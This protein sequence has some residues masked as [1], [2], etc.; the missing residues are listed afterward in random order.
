V[1]VSSLGSVPLRQYSTLSLHAP[2]VYVGLIVAAVRAM[3]REAP[4]SPSRADSRPP[5]TPPP[6]A[7]PAPPPADDDGGPRGW[8]LDGFPATAAQATLLEAALTGYVDPPAPV[9]SDAD[10]AAAALAAPPPAPPRLHA[11]PHGLDAV[12]RLDLEPGRTLRRAL[13][14]LTDAGSGAVYHIDSLP[15]PKAA[16]N[17]DALVP[18]GGDENYAAQ[19]PAHV[20][21]AG[22]GAAPLDAWYARGPAPPLRRVAAWTDGGPYAWDRGVHDAVPEEVCVLFGCAFRGACV[23]V[24]LGV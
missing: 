20:E 14:R 18:V 12:V 15:P 2:Q 19:L 7:L 10:V 5:S 4:P 21:A 22:A 16:L 8:L 23:V 3:G 9:L 17:R 13:G 11:A 6:H 24:C 1:W